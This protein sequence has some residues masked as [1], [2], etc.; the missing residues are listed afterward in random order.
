MREQSTLS[1]WRSGEVII[2]SYAISVHD[3]APAGRYQIEIGMYD[4]VTGERLSLIDAAADHVVL[5]DVRLIDG[6]P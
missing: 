6:A 2:D 3:A 4:A 1:T 5:T